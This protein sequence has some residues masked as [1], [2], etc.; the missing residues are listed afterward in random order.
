LGRRYSRATET[1]YR[2][3]P[4]IIYTAEL[5]LPGHPARRLI[6][7]LLEKRRVWFRERAAEAGLLNPE[8]VA[9]E[10]D[11][12]FDG[13]VASGAKRG[14]LVAAQTA[15]RIVRVVLAAATPASKRIGNLTARRAAARRSVKG[16]AQAC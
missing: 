10:L 13:A 11:V 8:Q 9:E 12:L 4:Y 14:D 7:K 6:E 15:K 2:G 5:T 1:Q 3:C 16:G